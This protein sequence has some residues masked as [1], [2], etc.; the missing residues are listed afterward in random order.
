M[1]WKKTENKI[2]TEKNRGT[3]CPLAMRSKSYLSKNFSMMAAPNKYETPRSLS[4]L[5]CRWD[6]ARYL[7]KG[8]AG[9]NCTFLSVCQFVRGLFVGMKRLYKY[10]CPVTIFFFGQ[11]GQIY[12]VYTYAPTHARIQGRRHL[13]WSPNKMIA[14]V[15]EIMSIIMGA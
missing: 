1:S 15:P 2:Q 9:H 4:C 12:A 5:Q 7:C 3:W 14:Y 13:L 11:L 6:C 8:V 10:A